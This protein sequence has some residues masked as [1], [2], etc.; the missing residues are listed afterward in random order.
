MAI[1]RTTS[2]ASARPVGRSGRGAAL[3]SPFRPTPHAFGPIRACV[4]LAVAVAAPLAA[5]QTWHFEPSVDSLFTLTDNVNLAPSGQRES[6][7][8]TQ[9]TPALRFTEKGA[10]TRLQG[11]IRAPILLYARTG[12][13]NNDIQP[14]VDVSG[15][16]ELAER[17]FFVEAAANVSQQYLSPFGPRPADLASA[18]ANRYTAQSYRVSPLLK[19]EASGGL[20]YQLRDDNIWADSSNTSF[21]AQRSYSNELSGKISREARPLGWAVDYD[22]SETRFSQ[23]TPLRTQLERAQLLLRQDATFEW[24]LSAGYEDNNYPDVTGSGAIY[25]GGVKWQPN[26]RTAI[27]AYTEHRFFGPSYRVSIDHRT[28]LSVWSLRASRDITTYPQQ[29]AAL[30]GGDNVNLLLNNL[31]SSRLTDPAQRQAFVNQ[32]IR[33]RGL[34][35]VLGGPLALVTQQ[36]TLQERLEARAGLIGARN[37]LIGSVYRQKA[38]PIGTTNGRVSDLLLAQE[39]NTQTGGNIVWTLKVTPL[40]TLATSAD[41]VRTVENVSDGEHARQLTFTVVLS[42]PLSPLTTVQVGGRWQRLLSNLDNSYRETALFF[43][44]RH[45]FR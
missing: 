41:Y 30:A 21:A 7:F 32:F 15:I 37:S 25:G 28:P 14:Q 33:D 36:V 19:G 27:D 44:M 8:I 10:S 5:A 13:E 42:A 3:V 38:E 6:D 4:T 18:T 1:T 26:S 16:A 29:L 12:S 9:L 24:S 2:R 17:L 22:R 40:Y 23:E 34:P 45:V 43:G 11:T 31:F 20:A 35:A 39:N